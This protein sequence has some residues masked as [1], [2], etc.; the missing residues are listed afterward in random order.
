MAAMAR[1]K[2]LPVP[3]DPAHVGAI[4]D[5]R[6]LV[7]RVLDGEGTHMHAKTVCVDR[8]LLYIGSDNAYPHY[9]EEHGCWVEEQKN[10]EAFM[11]EFYEG[12]WTRSTVMD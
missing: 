12:L 8:Q 1:A 10:V 4:V 5:E 3:T 2:V 6:F 7:K 11:K 9:N